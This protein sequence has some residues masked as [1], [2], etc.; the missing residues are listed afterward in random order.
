VAV[1]M[2]FDSRGLALAH[3]VFEGSIAE[4]KTLE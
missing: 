1:G 2:A 3:D 4:T